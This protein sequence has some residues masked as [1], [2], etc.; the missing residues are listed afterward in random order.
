MYR[1]VYNSK[2]R[3]RRKIIL[4]SRGAIQ[5]DEGIGSE[6]LVKSAVG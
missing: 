1:V 4:V 5:L 2:H 3:T 6:V